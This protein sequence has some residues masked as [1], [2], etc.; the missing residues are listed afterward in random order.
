[1]C[2]W[3]VLD[4]R[5]FH[6]TAFTARSLIY[7]LIWLLPQCI[8]RFCLWNAA[9]ISNF[10]HFYCHNFC[11]QIKEVVLFLFSLA[12]MHIRDTN[13]HTHTYSHL[14][15]L[16]GNISTFISC[17]TNC[18]SSLIFLSSYYLGFLSL[19]FFAKCTN[20]TLVYV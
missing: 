15:H 4:E 3:C 10:P 2:L 14:F 17:H 18:I 6:N 11:S 1:M 16:T 19:P 13:T 7:G 20:C 5:R 9:H 12:Q 8:L